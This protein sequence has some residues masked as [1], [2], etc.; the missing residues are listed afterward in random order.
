MRIFVAGCGETGLYIARRLISE[1]HDL[2]IMDRNAERCAAVRED[3]DALVIHGD[4]TSMA[5]WDNADMER[6]DIVLCVT[7]SDAVNILVCLIADSVAPG[8]GKAIRLRSPDYERWQNLL[9]HRGVK[10]DCVVHPE[11]KVVERIF[12]VLAI[13]GVSDVRDF[14]DG[15]VRVFGMNVDSDS[16]LD[17]VRLDVL[18]A[19]IHPHSAMIAMINRDQKVF[20]PH[21]EMALRAGDHV[22]VAAIAERFEDALG[23]MG[24]SRRESVRQVFIA[25]G[26]V[27]QEVAVALEHA[28]VAV[29][30][31]E[32][33][34]ELCHRLSGILKKSVVINADGTDQQTLV[35]ENIDGVDA[36]LALTDDDN[37][38]IVA[39]LLARR[40]GAKKLVVLVNKAEYPP[41][42]R[43]LGINTTVSLR[44]KAADAVL[45]YVRKGGVYSVRTYQEEGAEAIELEAPANS[46]YIGRP[47]NKIHLPR[48]AVVAAIVRPNGEA[49]IP[50]GHDRIQ[51]RDR[52]VL[53]AEE[54]LVPRIEADFLESGR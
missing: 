16:G 29:K 4:A 35:R 2:V 23:V 41:L 33:D 1:G 49:I 19:K 6:A 46:L 51:A 42:M 13:P 34:I 52:V 27:G 39:A 14:C 3:L 28:G 11:S 20:I 18:Q 36:F 21:G 24:A 26:E 43:R 32:K 5:A 7:D 10:L 22:H 40:L 37:A 30:L 50:R 31:F 54:H 17:G 44:I 47:L 48:N 12:R 45:S 8:A 38:N 9:A 15:R 25:G 53:F